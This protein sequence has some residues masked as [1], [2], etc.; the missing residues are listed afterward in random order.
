MKYVNLVIDNRSDQTDQYYTYG[1]EDESIEVGRKVYVPFARGRRL[2]AGY[3]FAVLPQPEEP[4]RRL[5]YVDH[6]DEEIS[7]TGEMVETCRWMTKRYLCRRIDAVRLFVPAGRAASGGRA[8]RK[9]LA[10]RSGERQEIAALT[11]EQQQ[12]LRRICEVLDSR[13]HHLFLLHGVTGSGKTEVYM[14]SIQHCCEQGRT[15]IMLV[16]EISLTKQIIDRFIGRFGSERL[17]VLHSRLTPRQRRDEWL[18]IRRGEA[19]IVI[20]AR[21][22]VFAPASDIGLIIMDEEHETSYKSDMTPKYDTV[23]VA[24]KRLAAW[25][26]VLLAGSA[27]PSVA[28]YQRSL[29]GIYERLTLPHR[30]NRVPLPQMEI[31]DMRRELRSGN[32]SVISR[33]LCEEMTRQ[34][35]AGR[36]VILFLNRRGYATY[37][38][39]RE[40]GH[41][42]ICPH[43]GISLTWHRS[44]GTGVCHYCGYE[45]KIP[46][47]CPQCGS[48][49]LRY[50]GSGTEKVEEAVAALFPGITS[51][52][53]DM[54]TMKKK[55]A[56][57][58]ILD[59]FGAGR[60]RILTGTQ[61]VAKGLDFPN[62]GLVGIVSADASLHVPDYRSPE[63]AFQLIIQAAGRAGRGDETGH[64][65]VQTRSPDHYAVQA[66]AAQDYRRF[67][68]AEIEVRR[69]LRYPPFAD[70]ILLRIIAPQREAAARAAAFWEKRLRTLLGSE[71]AAAILPVQEEEPA[72]QAT[73][74]ERRLII[75]SERGE[76]GLFMGALKEIREEER[77]AVKKSGSRKDH[78]VIIDVNPYSFW[79]N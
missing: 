48:R 26:G 66:A 16:P 78:T 21:S 11:A 41:V 50:R 62:V 29:D 68:R 27:T 34:L 55:G 43:C 67:F 22:A 72:P 42:M 7:L 15:A 65:I 14:R 4:L 53:L 9:P 1:C 44:S 38:A 13:S 24:I 64:V 76:R 60:T 18:R 56:V 51:A 49:G 59:D 17:A 74:F 3:V 12:T 25:N 47:R 70:L 10:E 19:D 20:G 32:T 73:D 23:E 71:R 31:V 40:C 63:R 52:R 61:V 75:K 45:E 33:R 79:R 5:R 36:Q 6:S 8:R 69:L 30:Y 57:E 58:R 39:C 2:R 37:I 28:T 54:D 77:T 35:Q 46:E